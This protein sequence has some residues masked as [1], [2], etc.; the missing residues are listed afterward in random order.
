MWLLR[1]PAI[2]YLLLA[3]LALAGSAY[4]YFE[5]QKQEAAKAVAR[6]AKPPATVPIEKFD[7]TRDT[8]AAD[9]VSVTGQVDVNNMMEVT[10]SKRGTVRDRWL[11]APVY[12][13]DAKDTSKPA[14]G[15]MF[16]HGD[17]TDDQLAQMIVGEGPVGPIMRINGT[18][19]DPST[20]YSALD[21]AGDRIR[22][23]PDAIYIDPFEAGRGEGLAASSNGRD[24]AI[25]I[26]VL[27]LLLGL[28][29]AARMFWLRRRDEEEEVY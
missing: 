27:G 29:G 2:V 17:A 25:G 5:D 14:I 8:G 9:E 4:F 16:Q 19:V 13:T 26:A 18:K 23:T 12:P 3:P 24:V 7:A 20:A 11:L 22:T 6:S 21:T 10:R 1:L 15:V 28:Y